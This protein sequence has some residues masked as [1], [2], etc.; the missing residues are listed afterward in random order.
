MSEEPVQK[1]AEWDVATG[2]G[3]QEEDRSTDG[4]GKH[5]DSL[6]HNHVPQ[7][8]FCATDNSWQSCNSVS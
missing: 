6:R 3:L 1:A 8:R 7:I 5:L 2:S 4:S